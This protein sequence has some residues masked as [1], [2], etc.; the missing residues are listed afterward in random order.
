[1]YIRLKLVLAVQEY[2]VSS[3]IVAEL[4]DHGIEVGARTA[5]IPTSCDP[6]ARATTLS[7]LVLPGWLP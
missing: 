3:K 7:T 2:E 6:R 5:Y 4:Q 1:M